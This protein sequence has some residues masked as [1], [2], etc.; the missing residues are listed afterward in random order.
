[1]S[2]QHS[3]EPRFDVEYIDRRGERRTTRVTARNKIEAAAIV[4]STIA[5]D[6][7]KCT[8]V[9]GDQP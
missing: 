3:P 9:V 7:R 4:L 8:P 2:E 5:T 1:M 6:V